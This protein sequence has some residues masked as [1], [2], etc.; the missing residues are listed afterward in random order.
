MSTNSFVVVVVCLFICFSLAAEKINGNLLLSVQG[1]EEWERE[2][3]MEHFSFPGGSGIKN[4]PAI[5]GGGG[6]I[7]WLGRSPAVGNGNPLQCSWLENSVDRGGWWATI[8][9][10]TKS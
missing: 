10:V 8:H 9:G 5:A 3:I 1:A 2:E 4:L 6:L 7:P